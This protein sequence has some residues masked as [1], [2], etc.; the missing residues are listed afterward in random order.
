MHVKK[1]ILLSENCRDQPDL[2]KTDV[3]TAANTPDISP[4]T[5]K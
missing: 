5:L 1:Y 4:L 2:N 3:E